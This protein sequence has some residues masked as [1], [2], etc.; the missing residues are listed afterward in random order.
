MNIIYSP[1]FPRICR[2]PRVKSVPIPS[3]EP[4][5]RRDEDGQYPFVLRG[6]VT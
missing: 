4:A 5:R 6:S 3:Y 1:I 2:K